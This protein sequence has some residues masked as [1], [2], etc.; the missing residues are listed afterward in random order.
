VQEL[1]RFLALVQRE[2]TAR[3]AR[4]EYGGA[5]PERDDHAWVALRDGWRLVAR[6]DAPIAADDPR[7]ARLR[8]LAETFSTTVTEHAP[9]LS[10]AASTDPHVLLTEVLAALAGRTAAARALV[11]DD[12]SPVVWGSSVAPRG[13]AD[14]D[15]ALALAA[16]DARAR[17]RG[18]DL[19]QTLVHGI[20]VERTLAEAGF[21]DGDRARVARIA[22][23]LRG[24]ESFETPEVGLQRRVLLAARAIGVA[25]AAR[26]DA[27]D[28]VEHGEHGGFLIRGF[29][30]IY[31]LVLVFAGPFSPLQAEGTV[32]RAMPVIERMVSGL[33]PIDPGPG[34]RAHVVDLFARSPG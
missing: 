26:P 25:R 18:V 8:A 17:L 19:A 21:S 29:D 24:D 27:V 10:A 34:G 33:P 32:R 20:D 1:D 11:I 28:Q 13:F 16:C 14:V 23:R 9:E 15:E 6:F 5:P 31:R 3:D 7:Q 2:L 22:A 30:R 4:L 12:T